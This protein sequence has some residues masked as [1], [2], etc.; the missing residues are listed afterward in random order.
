MVSGRN[1]E[2]TCGRTWKRNP[3]LGPLVCIIPMTSFEDYAA[4]T[5]QNASQALKRYPEFISALKSLDSVYDAVLPRLG[6]AGEGAAIFAGMSHAAFLC[7]VKLALSGEL[8]PAYMVIRGCLED[9]LYGF[10]LF[11][12]PHLKA[13]W[14]ARQQ[15]KDAKTKVRDE[16]KIGR[17]KK[18]LKEKNS[19]IATQF[20][21]AYE[22]TIDFGAHPNSL[23][24]TSHLTPMPGTADHMWQYVNVTPIDQA[25]ALRVAAIGGLSALNIYGVTFPNAFVES[26]A[27]P[28]LVIAHER[29]NALP[30]PGTEAEHD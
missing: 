14:M 5:Y 7:G 10:F 15:S 21:V 3:Q 9:A 20:D 25:M 26:G 4:G 23:A 2:H 29:L 17:M 27:A 1:V 8:P 6:A 19:P 11:H 12:N 16:F 13:V 18:L 22:A 24:F 30:D 28:L